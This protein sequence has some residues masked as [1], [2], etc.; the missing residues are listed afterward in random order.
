MI[1]LAL[2]NP[3]KIFNRKTV[4]PAAEARF[5]VPDIQDAQDV[6]NSQ[7]EK[8]SSEELFQFGK[9]DEDVKSYDKDN[10]VVRIRDTKKLSQVF[11]HCKVS[12]AILDE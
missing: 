12:I 6:A 4:K 3:Q 10:A 2:T 7:R 9:G 11:E 8:L 5:E 1:S